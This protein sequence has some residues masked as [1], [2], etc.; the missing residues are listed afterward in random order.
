LDDNP[1]AG[2]FHAVG[3]EKADV[4]GLKRVLMCALDTTLLRLGLAGEGGVVHL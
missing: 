3:G 4:L 2:T 1:L